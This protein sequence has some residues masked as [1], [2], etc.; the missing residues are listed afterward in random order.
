MTN[1]WR[2]ISQI[3]LMLI[4]LVGSRT[5]AETPVKQGSFYVAQ[6]GN[7]ANP[8]TKVQPW[9]SLKRVNQHTFSPGD[10]LF[11]A[12]GSS[13]YGGLRIA[14]SGTS[15]RPITYTAY[16]TGRAPAFTNKSYLTQKGRMI[17]VDGSYIVIDGLYFYDGIPANRNRGLTAR[18]AG[19]IFVSLNAEHIVIKNCEIENCPMGIQV[20]SQ[21]NLITHNNIHNCNIFLSYPNWGPVG[22]MVSNSNNEISYNK[23]VNYFSKGGSFG[24]DGGAIEIDDQGF[25]KDNIFIHHNYSTGNEGFLEITSGESADNIQVSYNVSDDYQEFIFFWEGTN[26]IVENNTVLCLKP[27]NSRVRVVFS[28]ENENEVTVRNNIFV[29]ANGLQV[30]AGDSVYSANKWNQP[31]SNNLYY[32]VDGTQDDPCGIL[33]GNG[34]M[35]ADPLFIDLE[36]RDL[37]LRAGSPAIDVGIDVGRKL[38]FEDKVVPHSKNPDIGAFEFI[39]H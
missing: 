7:D 38:D 39:K 5:Y 1:Y 27:P 16:G 11:F 12:R 28:F 37:H 23:I 9:K 33:L 31:H 6:N 15:N 10:T 14:S 29:L 24:A 32:V 21:H 17:Q 34:D 30:F 25:A 8:G 2:N 18:E 26:C 22:I 3:V 36:N 4:V 35:I 19:A 13:F 20:N